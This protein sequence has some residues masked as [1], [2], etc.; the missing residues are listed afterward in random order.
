MVRIVLIFIYITSLIYAKAL[1]I[2]D[3]LTQED[4][5]K[6]GV[7]I[8]YINLQKDQGISIPLE[9]Q[10]QNGD[11]VTIPTFIGEQQIN[12]DYI[13]YALNLKYGLNRDL[14]L[15]SILN[16]YA[17]TIYYTKASSYTSKSD[18]DFSSWVLGFNYQLKRESN[19]PAIL[20]GGV[21]D[22]LERVKFNNSNSNSFNS[23]SFSFKS[24]KL[25]A[26]T[27]YTVDP[28]VYLLNLSYYI[29]REKRFNNSLSIENANQLIVSPQLYF[30]I[31]PY[32]SINF[33][34]KYTH[35]GK[36]RLNGKVV[37]NSGSYITYLFGSSYEINSKLVLNF[38]AQHSKQLNISKDSFSVGVVYSF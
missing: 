16:F 10:T 20:I 36:N 26:T 21:A 12:Q 1:E 8:S 30:A 3:I 9:Y 5:F 27:Y 11:I 24:Y 6:L 4:R 14:E 38:T 2:D 29:N 34:M 13:N 31:S 28:L 22:I 25:S 37:S 17:S 23:K 7:I 18:S 33:G 32:S 35:F 15:F 19:T